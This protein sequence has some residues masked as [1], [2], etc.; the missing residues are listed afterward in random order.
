MLP[1]EGGIVAFLPSVP[2]SPGKIE[3]VPR[4]CVIRGGL[5]NYEIVTAE[6]PDLCPRVVAGRYVLGRVLGTGS[7]AVVRR[8]RDLRSGA[9]VA[10]KLFHRGATD[11]DLRQQR[12][13][14]EAL[15]NLD[16]PALVGLRDGGSVEGRPF[17]VTDLVNGPSLDVRLK[18]DGPLDP[19]AVRRVG[20]HVA[21]ALDHVHR[22][23]YIHRD[24]KPA[25]VL[26]GDDGRARLADFGISR[27]VDST[28]VTTTGCIVGTA[29]YLAPEQVRGE[30][31]GPP[32][33]VFALGLVMLEA[34]TGRREYPGR[35]M[36]SAV[37]RLHRVPTIPA[38]LPGGLTPLLAAMT[39]PDTGARPTA[40]EVAASLSSE[41]SPAAAP[42]AT[43]PT[44]V[45]VLDDD[46]PAA[47]TPQ[48][49]VGRGGHRGAHRVGRHRRAVLLPVA[50][51]ALLL[52]SVVGVLA[53]MM[54]IAPLGAE[55]AD[56]A[57]TI[58]AL[59]PV[60]DAPALEA[61]PLAPG[62]TP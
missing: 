22:A 15:A 18:Q 20:L 50:A 9:L 19:A 12:Q 41:T 39:N 27:A 4:I 30:H 51:A 2:R 44:P 56:T 62:D 24:V 54:G 61:V 25:N 60:P 37:A 42:P 57:T 14:M 55:V 1:A 28:A 59:Q 3:K 13:E 38:G 43:A 31:V 23:G 53:V 35:A 11:V 29:A 47:V 10:L 26:L 52:A 7:S 58:P 8:A 45:V 48:P 34:I 32:A 21:H 46:A 36:E 6:L 40:A 16:H 5:G 49:A 17:V 33:D